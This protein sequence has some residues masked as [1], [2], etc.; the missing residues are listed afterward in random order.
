MALMILSSSGPD[1]AAILFE[2]SPP[3]TNW[4]PSELAYCLKRRA[5]VVRARTRLFGAAEML[6]EAVKSPGCNY[7]KTRAFPTRAHHLYNTFP[8]G[9]AVERCQKVSGSP[10]GISR[11]LRFGLDKRIE[12]A[13][14]RTRT[15]DLISFRVSC[16]MPEG[17]VRAHLIF[18]DSSEY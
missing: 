10:S 6:L 13:D 7:Y 18:S 3:R 5:A 8:A 9:P 16:S 17:A 1:D 12:R 2:R 14:E 15:A 4:R 11:Y